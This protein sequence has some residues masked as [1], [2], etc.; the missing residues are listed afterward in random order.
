M[1]EMNRAAAGPGGDTQLQAEE[2]KDPDASR[3]SRRDTRGVP[4]PEAPKPGMVR[5]SQ[6]TPSPRE[7][8]PAPPPPAESTWSFLPGARAPLCLGTPPAHPQRWGAEG[9]HRLAKAG[10]RWDRGKRPL[11]G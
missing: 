4:P 1:A 11:F 7:A 2:R 8:R 5:G 6:E 10:S 3:F 9:Q